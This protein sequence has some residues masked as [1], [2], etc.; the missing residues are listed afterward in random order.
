MGLWEPF[1]NTALRTGFRMGGALYRSKIMRRVFLGTLAMGLAA[2][3]WNYFVAGKDKDGV[4]FFDKIPPWERS[5]SLII[6]APWLPDSKGRPSAIK[7]PYPYNWSLPL[8]MGYGAGNLMWGSEKFLDVA[9]DMFV[10]PFFSTFSQIGEEGI[11]VRSIIPELLRP[12]YDVARN[13]DWADRPIHIDE[14]FQKAPNAW[15]GK[16]DYGGRVRTG[17]GWKYLAETLNQFS[18]GGRMKSGFFDFYPEDL[19]TIL[20]PF[21][22]TQIGFGNEIK[23]TTQ[24]LL[25]GEAPAPSTVPIGRIFFGQDYDAANRFLAF[26]NSQAAKHPWMR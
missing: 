7:F 17:E 18:G 2:S 16:G 14:N 6:L 4:P 15:S 20:D 1:F 12:E 21:V 10:K 22:G 5:K 8:S 9:K 19:R 13:R 26:K 23:A 3:A 24:S 25:K 11:G